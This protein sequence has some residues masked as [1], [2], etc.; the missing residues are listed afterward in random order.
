[1]ANELKTGLLT[2]DAPFNAKSTGIMERKS[3]QLYI[4]D[5]RQEV[6]LLGINLGRWRGMEL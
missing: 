2:K 4:M 5:L 6:F 3:R 1:M